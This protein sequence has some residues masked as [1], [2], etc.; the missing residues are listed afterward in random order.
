MYVSQLTNHVKTS[1]SE[2]APDDVLNPKKK[3]FEQ[4]Q[5][6]LLT[7]GEGVACYRGVA[8]T[9]PSKGVMR[10]QTMKNFPIK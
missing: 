5:P 1:L 9:V 6:D 8:W 3:I 7:N 4:V 2:G 10:S